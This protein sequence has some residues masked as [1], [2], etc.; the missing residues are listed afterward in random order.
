VKKPPDL[1]E[2]IIKNNKKKHKRVKEV[3]RKTG[4]FRGIFLH[5][6][7]FFRISCKKRIN[8][9]RARPDRKQTLS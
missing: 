6:S 2:E 9:P 4:I 7:R 3:L 8:S 5:S 1:E